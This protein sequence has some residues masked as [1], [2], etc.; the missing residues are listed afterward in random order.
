MSEQALLAPALD[1]IPVEGP[2]G[3]PVI[4]DKGHESG[5]LRDDDR[6][7]QPAPGGGAAG[8]VAPDDP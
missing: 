2:E 1:D 7:Q 3:A 6:R 5:P 8:P 4:A